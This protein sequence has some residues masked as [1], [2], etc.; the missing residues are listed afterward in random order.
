MVYEFLHLL[1]VLQVG[2]T[3]GL[4]FIF[5]FA[6]NPGLARLNEEEYFRAMKFINQVILNP[7]FFLVF[8]G[9]AITMP[10][11]TFMTRNDSDMFIFTLFS[12][13]LYISG[14][15]LITSFKNVPLNNKLEKL[16]PKEFKD[17]FLWYKKP[18]NFWHNIRTFIGI[19]SFII[20]IVNLVF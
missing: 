20:I 6:V 7:L 10:A 4:L 18:W 12:T 13:I 8:I 15:I 14:V 16:D 17:V 3:S 5:S 1:V 9:P 11:L 19:A 2:L